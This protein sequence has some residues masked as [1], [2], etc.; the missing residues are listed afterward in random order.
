MSV[1]RG[2]SGRSRVE[3]TAEVVRNGAGGTHRAGKA[4]GLR[5]TAPSGE[6]ERGVDAPDLER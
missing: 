6:V 3:Q 1:T 2:N 5:P 4:R